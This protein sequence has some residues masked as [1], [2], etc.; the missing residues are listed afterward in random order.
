[1]KASA[2]PLIGITVLLTIMLPS[3]ALGAD[4]VFLKLDGIK[5]E[6]T[7]QVHSEEIVLLSY[8]QSFGRPDA[9]SATSAAGRTAGAGRANCGAI[10][11]TKLVDTASPALLGRVLNGTVINSGV[12][13]FR[14]EAAKPFEYYKVTLTDVVIHAISQTDV[15]PTDPTTILEQIS[16]N[17]RKIKFDYMPQKADG[18]SGQT[19]TFSWDCAANKPG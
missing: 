12:I 9:G 2:M 19:V 13:T 18:S 1:M 3:T 11:V 16:M 15:S 17:A 10:T 7:D 5:G 8:T 6:S 4:S 14:K